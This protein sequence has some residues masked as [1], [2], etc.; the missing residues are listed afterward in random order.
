MI[1]YNLLKNSR[2]SI[3]KNKK[4]VFLMFIIILFDYVLFPIPTLANNKDI[5]TE[6]DKII[7]NID[8]L[9]YLND[10][11]DNNNDDKQNYLKPNQ[12]KKIIKT[13]YHTITAYTSEVAQC[14][15]SP[16]ITAN[17][18]NL[19]EHGIEDSIAANFLPFGAKVRIP[20]LFGNRIFIVRDRMNKR[21]ASKIDVWMKNKKDA[22][23]FGARIAKIEILEY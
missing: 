5:R 3:K 19:C 18:F 9:V 6:E 17:G 13:G 7:N 8:R 20:S 11:N 16:C 1:K 22:I 15:A 4:L 23:Q 12:D 21:H 10:K 14:D 2:F